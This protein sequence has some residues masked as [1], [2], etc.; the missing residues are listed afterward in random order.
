[1]SSDEAEGEAMEDQ[2]AESETSRADIPRKVETG[3]HLSGTATTAMQIGMV[4]GDIVH[5]GAATPQRQPKR[6]GQAI[7]AMVA[8]VALAVGVTGG[9][10]LDERQGSVQEAEQGYPASI[11]TPHGANGEDAC[12]GGTRTVPN[13]KYPGCEIATLARPHERVQWPTGASTLVVVGEG[14]KMEVSDNYGHFRGLSGGVAS[15]AGTGVYFH[16]TGDYT[17]YFRVYGLHSTNYC[18]NFTADRDPKQSASHG[19]WYSCN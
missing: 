13:G 19:R 1:M 17:G 16:P 6:W 4:R 7:W 14:Y 18:I 9:M 15:S 8:I 12:K 2:K 11:P 3:N 5:H 10:L